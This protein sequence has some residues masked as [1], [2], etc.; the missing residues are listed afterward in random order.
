M[1]FG[2]NI[3]ITAQGTSGQNQKTLNAESSQKVS[4]H[5]S[6]RVWNYSQDRGRVLRK[7]VINEAFSTQKY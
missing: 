7:N 5:T 1:M 4:A 6:L 2:A 3:E